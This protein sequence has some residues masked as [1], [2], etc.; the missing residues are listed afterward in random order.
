VRAG[1]KESGLGGA[2]GD[3]EHGGDVVHVEAVELCEE[4]D[5]PLIVRELRRGSLERAADL[6]PTS[7]GLGRAGRRG[8]GVAVERGDRN[9][10]FPPRVDREAAG[11]R[12]EPGGH[13]RLPA[14][15]EAGERAAR[16]EEDLLREILDVRPSAE[17]AG[18]ERE[19]DALVPCDEAAHRDGL[20]R[21]T[22]FERVGVELGGSGVKHRDCACGGQRHSIPP[23]YPL[24]ERGHEKFPGP[25]R[26][27]LSSSRGTAYG[28]VMAAQ[29]P[30]WGPG[31]PPPAKK[32]FPTW[33]LVLLVLGGAFF[34]VLP[35]MASLAIYGVRKYILNAKTAEARNVIHQLSKDAVA[36]YE[37][38]RTTPRGT[39]ARRLCASVSRPVPLSITS[40]Q[41]MR[42]QSAEADWEA[43][44]ARNAGFACLKFSMNT[45]QYYRYSY[46]ATG[47]GAPGDGFVAL[48]EGD[49]NGDGVTSQFRLGGSV[50]PDK[51]LVV[52]PTIQEKDP[53][54]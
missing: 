29:P 41:G 5:V 10:T 42:Y 12:E 45:P 26:R 2:L 46:S 48:A 27:R 38:E 39:V 7:L 51:A 8:E 1:A 49:L 15:L 32:G 16:A 40:V 22:G 17:A 21:T 3:P 18:E 54:E 35:V 28:G 23:L 13:A 19:D 52:A 31:Q 14:G 9:L 36:A 43:D 30:P 37:A 25:R 34:I 47:P 50:G 33:L 11:D 6:E 53:E 44:A 4:E 20:A 24:H